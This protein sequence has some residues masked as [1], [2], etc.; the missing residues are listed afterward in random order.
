M[1]RQ[2]THQQH[3]DVLPT[4]LNKVLVQAARSL[5]DPRR[6]GKGNVIHG[7]AE[8]SPVMSE[9]F[10]QFQRALDELEVNI[11]KAKAVLTRDL[12]ACQAQEAEKQ[13]KEHNGRA[14][15]QKRD[16]DARHAIQLAA[17]QVAASKIKKEAEKDADVVML[18]HDPI[19]DVK[20][21]NV[22]SAPLIPANKPPGSN[23]IEG[24]AKGEQ[25][26]Q[27][28]LTAVVKEA[29]QGE[30]M[31][32]ELIS[33]PNNGRA[34]S[35]NEIA[36][37]ISTEAGTAASQAPQSGIRTI[38]ETEKN[39]DQRD[40]NSLLPGLESYAN[41][42]TS[43]NDSMDIDAGPS[44]EGASSATVAHPADV[45]AA[46]VAPASQLQPTVTRNV[47]P[48]ETGST[49]NPSASAAEV[50]GA[51]QAPAPTAGK[52]STIS[53]DLT[54]PTELD[55]LFLHS[56]TTKAPPTTISTTAANPTITTTAT[57][58]TTLPSSVNPIPAESTASVID[59]T[60][61]HTTDFGQ[62]SNQFV[63]DL[64]DFTIDDVAD[65][66]MG[67]VGMASSSGNPAGITVGGFD[68]T[69]EGGDDLSFDLEGLMAGS[70][71]PRVTN[72]P[73]NATDGA[74]GGNSNGNGGQPQ[75]SNGAEGGGDFSGPFFDL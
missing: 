48:P 7:Q 49:A 40:L 19:V 71:F 60:T 73:G 36:H 46:V 52:T 47:A 45:S 2:R 43:G 74:G 59:M 9:A 38:G 24:K 28:E 64:F 72:N 35:G 29:S 5:K 57:N 21:G 69:I 34:A 15:H 56:D 50:K 23:V 33:A 14:E 54:S 26:G 66:G 31:D 65:P 4:A 67:G 61:G 1:E 68:G 11:L 41:A 55:D 22:P 58:S 30:E 70:D 42:S 16:S 62:E 44:K 32:I 25:A 8:A 27:A 53:I 63:D 37:D 75:P 39:P 12:R 3:L 20:M 51:P 18:D 10:E 6:N 17:A 13:Q